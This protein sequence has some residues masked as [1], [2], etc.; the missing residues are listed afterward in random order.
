[1]CTRAELDIIMEEVIQ[2]VSQLLGDKLNSVILFGSY[3]YFVKQNSAKLASEIPYVG[4]GISLVLAGLCN[5]V[6]LNECLA[7]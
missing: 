3:V 7:A 4:A 1:M 2:Q 6:L 5:G